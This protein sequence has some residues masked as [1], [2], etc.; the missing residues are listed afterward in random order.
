MPETSPTGCV[1]TRLHA[2]C[3]FQAFVTV[4]SSILVCIP[5]SVA[6]FNPAERWWLRGKW[7]REKGRDRSPTSASLSDIPIRTMPPACSL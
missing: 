3:L 6:S 1:Y 5:L 4:R 7:R 2:S